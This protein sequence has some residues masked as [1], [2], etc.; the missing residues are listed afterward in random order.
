MDPF[1]SGRVYFI[2]SLW[3]SPTYYSCVSVCVCGQH[4]NLSVSMLN[5]KNRK[6]NRDG[7][8]MKKKR[9]KSE[10][11][12]KS[13]ILNYFLRSFF[14]NDFERVLSNPSSSNVIQSFQSS[15]SSIDDE[16]L[17]FLAD[18]NDDTVPCISDNEERR[19][20]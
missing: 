13:E 20:C 3:L 18:V 9:K 19:I 12:F 7:F 14:C 16:S 1:L 8:R 2:F 6:W 4:R 11:E 17:L 5:N 10:F 15:S